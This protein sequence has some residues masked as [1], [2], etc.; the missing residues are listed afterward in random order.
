[1]ACIPLFQL[2]FLHSVAQLRRNSKGFVGYISRRGY[3]GFQGSEQ[4]DTLRERMLELCDG[5]VEALSPRSET[6][7]L[8]SL[9]SYST[10]STSPSSRVVVH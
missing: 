8:P 3:Q 7:A 1:M 6:V 5:R 10:Y 2:S 9:S 4:G